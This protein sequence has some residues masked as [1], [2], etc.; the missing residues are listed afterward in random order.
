MYDT[1]VL[2]RINIDQ[3]VTAT[4]RLLFGNVRKRRPSVRPTTDLTVAARRAVAKSDE[5]TIYVRGNAKTSRLALFGA[6]AALAWLTVA[7]V[8]LLA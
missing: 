1:D 5:R 2:E 3:I 6:A 4:D 7:V 8:C